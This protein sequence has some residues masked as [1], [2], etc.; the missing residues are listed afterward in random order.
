MGGGVRAGDGTCSRHESGG[1]S[2]VLAAPAEALCPPSFGF[3]ARGPHLS[4][5]V[6]WLVPL[7]RTPLRTVAPASPEKPGSH[8]AARGHVGAGGSEP[9]LEL[10]RR[11][12]GDKAG[13]LLEN[14][15][16]FP[17]PADS[18]PWGRDTVLRPLLPRG[19]LR[20]ASKASCDAA[21]AAPAPA[22]GVHPAAPGT[23]GQGA[24]WAGPGVC[25]RPAGTR[26]AGNA[27]GL[28]LRRRTRTSLA[29]LR[30]C[31][32]SCANIG[33]P[34]GACEGASCG[35]RVFARAVRQPP[36]NPI[37]CCPYKGEE[38]RRPTPG[39]RRRPGEEEGTATGDVCPAQGRPASPA[40]A[41]SG[42]GASNRVSL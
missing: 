35:N 40:A 1:L 23:G 2:I 24:R 42:K 5:A 25:E 11:F 8:R 39:R 17:A 27:P 29:R 21:H 38:T 9:P 20:T 18:L 10:R 19:C 4:R 28:R 41:R 15:G 33:P 13:L 34:P 32:L 7:K 12:R 14:R 6:S 30:R 3:G 16:P 31:R 36:P 26:A 37:R 22:P